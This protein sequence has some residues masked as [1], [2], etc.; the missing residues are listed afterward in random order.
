MTTTKRVFL[1]GDSGTMHVHYVVSEDE[2]WYHCVGEQQLAELPNPA[3]YPIQKMHVYH[4]PHAAREARIDTLVKQ[5]KEWS[6]A[7]G[8]AELIIARIDK[9]ATIERMVS[10][11]GLWT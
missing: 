1:C 10:E 7:I 8:R 2:E 11:K 4:S 6:A 5:V 3:T 9:Q